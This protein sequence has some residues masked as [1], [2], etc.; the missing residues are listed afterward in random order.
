MPRSFLIK[1]KTPEFNSSSGNSCSSPTHV[2]NDDSQTCDLDVEVTDMLIDDYRMIR[3]AD[4]QDIRKSEP[5][6]VTDKNGNEKSLT[7]S[8]VSRDD[9]IK[10]SP[11]TTMMPLVRRST[12]WSPAADLKAEV[13]AAAVAEMAVKLLAKTNGFNME[14][15]APFTP[16]AANMASRSDLGE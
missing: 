15:L 5:V 4:L 12:I 1:K 9:V 8:V 10:R 7:T 2:N 14:A 6:M 11:P 16:L 3:Q 13:D